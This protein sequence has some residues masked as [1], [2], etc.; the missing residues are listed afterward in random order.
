MKTTLLKGFVAAGMF[1]AVI[2]STTSAEAQLIDP[3]R[4]PITNTIHSGYAPIS[5]YAQRGGQNT[6][7]VRSNS[8]QYSLYIQQDG[9]LVLYNNS[10]GIWS[11]GVSQVLNQGYLVSFSQDGRITLTA[12]PSGFKMWESPIPEYGGFYW[13]LQDDGNFVRYSHNGGSIST[14]THGGKNRQSGL[15]N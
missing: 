3:P 15:I 2:S 1:L 13:I 10:K 8:G 9:N 4:P 5:F 14:R 7:I 6:L 12:S 11:T